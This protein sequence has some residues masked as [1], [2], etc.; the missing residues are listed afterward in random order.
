MTKFKE[1]VSKFHS[2]HPLVTNL[3]ALSVGVAGFAFVSSKIQ[4]NKAQTEFVRQ[5]TRNRQLEHEIDTFNHMRTRVAWE[6]YELAELEAME[7]AEA[8][9]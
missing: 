5:N 7:K 1:R 8:A 9:S 6:N 3:V 4:L 2:N